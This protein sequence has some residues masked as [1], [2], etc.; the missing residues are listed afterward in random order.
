M[1]NTDGASDEPAGA[2]QPS[3]ASSDTSTSDT[4]FGSALE[5]MHQLPSMRVIF[6]SKMTLLCN[7]VD[8]K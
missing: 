7:V 5:W 2:D 4:V 6:V 8:E 1:V 3:A